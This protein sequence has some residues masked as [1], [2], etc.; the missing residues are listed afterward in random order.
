[1]V[2]DH[3]RV[4]HDRTIEDLHARYG[5]R[6]RLVVDLDTPL[7]PGFTLPGATLTSVEA[8][9]HRASFALDSV[10]AVARLVAAVSVRDL[11]GR[12]TGHRGRGR[13]AVRGHRCGVTGVRSR[14]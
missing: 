5:S 4:V 2:I 13:A 3:G 10:S 14:Y 12:R 9:G 11:S 7:A 1:V 6:R 8:D